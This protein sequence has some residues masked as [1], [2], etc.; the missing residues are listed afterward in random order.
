M[1]PET[2]DSI[3]LGGSMFLFSLGYIRLVAVDT[4]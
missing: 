4:N 3:L 2:E 1:L